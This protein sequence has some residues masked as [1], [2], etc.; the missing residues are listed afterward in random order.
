MSGRLR[1]G[2]ICFAA[3]FAVFLMSVEATASSLMTGWAA[4]RSVVSP[5]GA[6]FVKPPFV[7]HRTAR[8]HRAFDRRLLGGLYYDGLVPA[9]DL[10]A[11]YDFDPVG[12]API[13]DE[14]GRQHPRVLSCRRSHEVVTVP[15]E[16]GYGSSRTVSI[17]RC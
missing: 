10:T 14:T 11:A 4:H 9:Y 5:A 15:A 12:S 3:A 16:F 2:C 8:R 1:A 17:T 13:F 6:F 7:R